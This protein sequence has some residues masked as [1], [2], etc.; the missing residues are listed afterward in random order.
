VAEFLATIRRAVN[1]LE[2]E[3]AGLATSWFWY[4]SRTHFLDA[5]ELWAVLST[6]IGAAFLDG[7][8]LLLEELVGEA[9]TL[10]EMSLGVRAIESSS[11]SGMK[12]RTVAGVKVSH[13]R[14]N[15]SD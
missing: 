2:T 11:S 6:S 7:R 15:E 4:A 1:L 13:P 10:L 8:L 5:W 14:N 9:M 12:I 3:M